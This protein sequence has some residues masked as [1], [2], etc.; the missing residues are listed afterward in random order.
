MRSD[1]ATTNGD[2]GRRCH[3]GNVLRAAMIATA[4]GMAC[5]VLSAPPWDA[6]PQIFTEAPLLTAASSSGR[7]AI[8][9]LVVD[10]TAVIV[11]SPTQH[12]GGDIAQQDVGPPSPLSNGVVINAS[13]RFLTMNE[14][15]GFYGLTNQMIAYAAAMRYAMDDN[16]ALHFPN[17]PGTTALGFEDLFDID[18]TQWCLKHTV[19][20]VSA[21]ACSEPRVAPNQ[22]GQNSGSNNKSTRDGTWFGVRCVTP[23]PRVA[24]ISPLKDHRNDSS[25]VKPR[26]VTSCNVSSPCV[27]PLCGGPPAS[28]LPAVSMNKLK[29]WLPER[30]VYRAANAAI[31]KW[32]VHHIDKIQRR[33]AAHKY[34]R[35]HN[36]FFRFPW[37]GNVHGTALLDDG[38]TSASEAYFMA[39]MQ[40]HR[41]VR[42]FAAELLQRL[43]AVATQDAAPN[44]VKDEEQRTAVCVVAV[45]LRI[46]PD[47]AL[48]RVK[49]AALPTE[50]KLLAM[51]EAVASLCWAPPTAPSPPAITVPSAVACV[52][53]VCIGEPPA[54]LQSAIR[55][56]NHRQPS[57]Q[58]TG[59]NPPVWVVLKE[60]LTSRRVGAAS[61]ALVKRP[62]HQLEAKLAGVRSVPMP[63]LPY[64]VGSQREVHERA[65]ISRT[66]NHYMSFVDLLILE[67]ASVAVLTEFSSL[68]VAVFARRCARHDHQTGVYTISLQTDG[69]FGPPRRADCLDAAHGWAGHRSWS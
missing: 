40:P 47:A 49:G 62:H 23:P 24:A 15:Y 54:A 31:R 11:P 64:H 16:R 56:W 52:V 20:L 44:H 66:Q 26:A 63:R 67:H 5:L 2:R 65:G 68:K 55:T 50:A 53:Y 6:S 58:Q 61:A 17:G 59:G 69:A 25:G 29:L 9:A 45:H 48:I 30:T 22:R 35:H 10:S 3:R 37:S 13:G 38:V 57:S 36:F 60:D 39:S 21:K 14:L 1:E 51:L 19:Q 33:S 34:V 8:A 27:A 42:V 4:V 18:E 32:G 28:V 41:L 46:E 7:P 12:N 43:H